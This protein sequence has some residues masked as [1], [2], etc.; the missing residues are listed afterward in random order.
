L[1][2]SCVPDGAQ[3]EFYTLSGERVRSAA[4]ASNLCTWDGRNMNGVYVSTGIYFFAIQKGGEV[5]QVGK[6]L[7][8][9]GN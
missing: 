6:L 3:V 5:I 1:K 2:I 9:T 4:P 8:Q 7:V